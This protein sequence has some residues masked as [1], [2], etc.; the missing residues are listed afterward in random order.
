[1]RVVQLGL[2]SRTFEV[3]QRS[4]EKQF[5][6]ILLAALSVVNTPAVSQSKEWGLA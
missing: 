4:V 5:R 2:Y 1:V 6:T 3:R